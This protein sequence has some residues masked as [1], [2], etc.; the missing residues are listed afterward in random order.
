MSSTADFGSEIPIES[1][2]ASEHNSG[3][4]ETDHFFNAVPSKADQDSVT[5][6]L[7]DAPLLR[8]VASGCPAQ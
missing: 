5:A 6:Q 8:R 3:G 2:G 1:T 7:Q 4:C